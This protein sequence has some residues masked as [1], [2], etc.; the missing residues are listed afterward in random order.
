MFDLQLAVSIVLLAI[1]AYKEAS[2]E[3]R[4]ARR[5]VICSI[6]NRVDRPS[7]WGG[8]VLTVV[9]KRWQYSAMTAPGDPNLV[10]WPGAKDP[11]WLE[12]LQDAFDAINGTL[13]SPVPGADSYHD[14]SCVKIPGD[15]TPENFVAQL[16]RIR[17]YNTDHDYELT[18]TA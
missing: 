12:C 5:G 2:G 7:W 1:A 4:L 8:D 10:R 13:A 6:L 18:A 16:G 11:V 15:H 9:C 3:P 17:F 14:V